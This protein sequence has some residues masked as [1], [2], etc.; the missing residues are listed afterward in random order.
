MKKLSATGL[1]FLSIMAFAQSHD[2]HK[3]NDIE[4]VTISKKKK[5]KYKNP[6]HEILAKLVERKPINNPENLESYY[7]ENHTR[8]EI[9]MNSLGN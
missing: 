7:S 2:N 8:M 3:S 5:K 1:L 9:M 6:A 4:V